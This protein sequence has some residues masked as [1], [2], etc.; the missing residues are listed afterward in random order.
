VKF[1]CAQAK[2]LKSDGYVVVL[3]ANAAWSELAEKLPEFDE[4]IRINRRKFVRDILYR[5]R[6]F[7]RIRSYR[8][9]I[10]INPHFSRELAWSESIVAACGA[11]RRIGQTGDI[12]NILH[13]HRSLA[14]RWYSEIVES[15]SKEY[16]VLR[17]LH[18]ASAV[19]VSGSVR[20]HGFP[21]WSREPIPL[22]MP[23]NYFIVAPGAGWSP[24]RWPAK[25]FSEVT[26]R[27][28]EKQRW[29]PVI[30]GS[31]SER[32][33][34]IGITENLSDIDVLDLT[35]RTD[36]LQLCAIVARARIVV[37]NESGIAH[38]A[39]LFGIRSVWVMGGGHFG[40]F[41]PRTEE[42]CGSTPRGVSY[43]MS[44]YGCNWRCIYLSSH[45]STVPCVEAVSVEA[46]WEEIDKASAY[47]DSGRVR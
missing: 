20:E 35:G 25:R 6:L 22:S 40:R 43:P 42:E 44:C 5:W 4:V 39:A 23:D 1:G 8:L 28:Y 9:S 41:V 2:Q 34:S 21:E 47:V 32:A 13:W 29:N 15:S 31:T 36:L 45:K 26:R 17:N 7:R 33:L 10:A 18:F 27:L 30:C 14:N 16:E 11:Q 46:V 3:V 19:G 12:L 24:R 37:A 38:L